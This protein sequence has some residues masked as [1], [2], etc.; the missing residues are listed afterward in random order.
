M[1]KPLLALV[2][3]AAV[4]TAV[5]VSRHDTAAPSSGEVK[6]DVEARNPWTHLRVTNDPAEF[7]FVIVS[8]RTGGHRPGVFSRAV[9]QI[10]L[11]LLS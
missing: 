5:A 1:K 4:A 3:L 9:D 2:A 7:R 10:N 8:D 11:S 6:V